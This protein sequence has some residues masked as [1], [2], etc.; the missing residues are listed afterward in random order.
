MG[1]IDAAGEDRA[2]ETPAMA[3]EDEL[4]VS[5]GASSELTDSSEG[6]EEPSKGNKL[7]ISNQSYVDF[8]KTMKRSKHIA[9]P[10]YLDSK[11]FK[12]P[13]TQFFF[14]KLGQN[15]TEKLPKAVATFCNNL[16]ILKRKFK[17]KWQLRYGCIKDGLLIYFLNDQ[18]KCVA[19]GCICLPGS[20]FEQ[21]IVEDTE[22]KLHYLMVRTSQPRRPKK[23]KKKLSYDW[24]I[25]AQTYEECT[26]LKA[27]IEKYMK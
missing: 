20:T 8:W 2:T 14:Y 9:E 23:N 26:K 19:L 15:P 27:E 21:D 24:K 6:I 11:H 5:T 25:G 1:D 17:A 22:N 10:M 4:E 16:P 13:S 12:D 3:E 7:S 18:P